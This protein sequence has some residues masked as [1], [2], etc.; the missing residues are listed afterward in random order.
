MGTGSRLCGIERDQPGGYLPRVQCC[1]A[2]ESQRSD[3]RITTNTT[4]NVDARVQYLGYISGGLTGTAFDGSSN[5]NSLQVTVRKAF[6]HG[7]T[8]QASYTWSKDLGDL[9]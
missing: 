4:E 9:N 2:G 1:R 5:Y 8:M 3:Q 7:F 6:S